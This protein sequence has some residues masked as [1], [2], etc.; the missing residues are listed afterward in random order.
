MNK[1]HE[2]MVASFQILHLSISFKESNVV[3]MNA[4]VLKT[5]KGGK[6]SLIVRRWK[7]ETPTEVSSLT[8]KCLC[9]LE[10]LEEIDQYI[11]RSDRAF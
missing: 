4:V 1:T 9:Q 6:S 2:E 3:G 10:R 7:E 8:K 5:C 11:D